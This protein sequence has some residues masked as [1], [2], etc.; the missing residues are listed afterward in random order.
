MPGIGSL[1]ESSAEQFYNRLVQQHQQKAKKEKAKFNE[2]LSKLSA[3]AQTALGG[4][5]DIT[6]LGTLDTPVSR[7]ISLHEIT[8]FPS[9]S[10]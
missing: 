2:T 5:G 4:L 3:T 7:G 8:N 6:Q 1:Q 10:L 9:L